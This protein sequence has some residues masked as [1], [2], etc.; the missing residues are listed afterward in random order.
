MSSTTYTVG[1]TGICFLVNHVRKRQ[2]GSREGYFALTSDMPTNF[3]YS[4]AISFSTPFTF[5]HCAGRNSF[6]LG[7]C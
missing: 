2:E 6:K 5:C 4:L 7:L 3:L 1:R